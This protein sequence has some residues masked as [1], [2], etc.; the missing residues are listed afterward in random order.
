MPYESTKE[1]LVPHFAPSNAL[2]TNARCKTAPSA[3]GTRNVLPVT[4]PKDKVNAR[5]ESCLRGI[6]QVEALRQRKKDLQMEMD[7]INSIME[8]KKIC[9]AAGAYGGVNQL[10]ETLHPALRQVTAKKY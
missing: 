2:V 5:Y 3:I 4:N 9:L 8:H 1:L 7:H 10:I 6:G